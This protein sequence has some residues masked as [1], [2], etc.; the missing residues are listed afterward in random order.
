MS[1]APSPTATVCS[2][3]TPACWAKSRNAFALP[4][5]SITGPT[6]RPVSL[7]STISSSLAATKSSISSCASGSMTCR[8]PPDTTPQ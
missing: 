7:P 2:I 8:K 3:G 1:L 6:T 4:A 5:R